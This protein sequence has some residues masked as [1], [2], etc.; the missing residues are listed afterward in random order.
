M[1]EA[2]W[3]DA[4]AGCLLGGAVGDA[5]GLACEG[6]TPRRQALL[7][8]DTDGP[9]L[10][11]RRGMVSDDTEHALMTALAVLASGDDTAEFAACLA[12]QLRK[13]ILELPA[14][15][16]LATLKACM[17]LLAGYGPDRSGVFSAGNGPCM[18]APILG[19][20]FHDDS[21][22]LAAMVRASTRITHTDPKAEWG[23]LA[24]A[25]AAAHAAR[26][27]AIAPPDFAAFVEAALPVEAVELF[28]LVKSAQESAQRGDTT[29]RFAANCG[30]DH[31]VSGYVYHTVPVALHAW[32]RSPND[33]RTAVLATVRCGGDTD[34]VA[35]IV[36]GI[37][38]AGTGRA[39]VPQDWLDRL[40]EW[41][42]TVGWM[43]SMSGQLA[44]ARNG[45]TSGA[46]RDAPYPAVLLR[47][48]FFA[49]LVIV[50]GFRRLA[51]P[52]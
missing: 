40:M 50:H 26:E 21:A 36:G 41:P 44:R 29:E 39:G 48:V 19:V 35:A 24:V 20:C 14:A 9:R 4:I 23:A 45:R 5:V 52:Y 12:R 3:Q 34:T 30:F 27:G 33:L 28:A 18:R 17:R 10:L 6:L 47:N 1:T 51:P 42:R 22:R 31:G 43:E 38:G 8:P 25:M 11:G 46:Y 7:F 2:R 32:M 37:I 49:A 13:W 16:G 15:T